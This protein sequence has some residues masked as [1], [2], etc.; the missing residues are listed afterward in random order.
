MHVCAQQENTKKGKA[1]RKEERKRET[2]RETERERA[3]IRADISAGGRS[4]P[5]PACTHFL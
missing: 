3:S 2:Q 4:Y 1:N 5:W